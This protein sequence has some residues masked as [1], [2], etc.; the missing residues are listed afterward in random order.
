MAPG[1]PRLPVDAEATAGNTSGPAGP[2]ARERLREALTDREAAIIRGGGQNAID[3]VK[4]LLRA[5]AHNR[6]NGGE[7][8]D[9]FMQ[10]V[11]YDRGWDAAYERYTGE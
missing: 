4:Y 8:S 6:P 11:C 9:C 5:L 7:H 3:V 1:Q 10:C 2:E